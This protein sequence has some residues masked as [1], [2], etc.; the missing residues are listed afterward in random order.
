HFID[1]LGVIDKKTMGNL[2]PD[3]HKFLDSTLHD[4]RM[5]FVQML[6]RGTPSGE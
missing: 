6:N 1:L 2:E 5:A 4:L 3:E